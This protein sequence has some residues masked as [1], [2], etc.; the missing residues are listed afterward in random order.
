[1][2]DYLLC[3]KT[4]RSQM[5]DVE[6]QTAKITVEE[7]MQ[8][9]TIQTLEIDL[10]SAKSETKQL[11][12]DTEQ[13]MKAKGQIC[14]QILE[15]QRKIVSLESDSSTLAQT[16]ELIQQ[17]K[18]SLSSKL[19]E[20]RTYFTKVGEEI[21]AKLQEQQDWVNSHKI[22]GKLGEHVLVKDRI[23]EQTGETEGKSSIDGDL[24]MDNLG[25]EAKNNLIAK[26]DAAKAKLDEISRMKSKL[27]M[28]NSK[29]KQLLEQVKF[30][31]NDFE[32]ELRTMDI[33][34]LEE[35]HNALLLDKAG[36]IEYLQ[37]LPSQIETLKGISHVITCA[38][39]KE[40]KVG[41]DCCV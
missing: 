37:T 30:K 36:V 20:M 14:S 21:N 34:T 4:L 41:V 2:E 11:K 5:N 15:R 6:D 32:P 19:L 22:S 3:M 23:S 17:E 29:M 33:K 12:E 28:E 31:A 8:L 18:A 27:V 7:Q 38:C 13:M 35:E 24:I 10:N 25:S 16:L 9:T 1:M 39:G 26:L 40:Y